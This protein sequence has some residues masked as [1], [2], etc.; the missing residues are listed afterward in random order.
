MKR[1]ARKGLIVLAIAVM[2][3]V[4]IVWFYVEPSLANKNNDNAYTWTEYFYENKR[5]FSSTVKG[6]SMEPTF[7]EDDTILWVEVNPSELEV[8]DIIVYEHPTKPS[9]ELIAHRIIRIIE[10]EKYLFETKGDGRSESDSKTAISAYFVSEDDIKGLVVG[11]IY[12]R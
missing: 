2:L 7:G 10:G 6:D 5:I 9:R 12:E 1:T 4:P 11:I 8:D 3:S